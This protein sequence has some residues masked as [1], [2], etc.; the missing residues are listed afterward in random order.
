MSFQDVEYKQRPH[1]LACEVT[2]RLKENVLAW[3]D[4]KGREGM[5][6]YKDIVQLRLSFDAARVRRARY[7]LDIFTAD[8]TKLRLTSNTYQGM[9]RYKPRHTSYRAFLTALHERTA[10]QAKTCIYTTGRGWPFYVLNMTGWLILTLIVI[11][12][13]STFLSASQWQMWLFLFFLLIYFVPAAAMS[14]RNNLPKTYTPD[15]IPDYAMPESE[16][17]EF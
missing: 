14:A 9:G 2:F 13:I 12:G 8:G 16:A 15:A 1:P 4:A 11:Q 17:D 7:V 3:F 5:I 10:Q 6:Y